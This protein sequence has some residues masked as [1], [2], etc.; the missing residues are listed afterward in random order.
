MILYNALIP[1]I[2]LNDQDNV[3]LPFIHYTHSYWIV[4]TFTSLEPGQT[5]ILTFGLSDMSPS[6]M[7][8]ER[9]LP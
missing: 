4:M 6:S 3:R 9:A 1:R 2:T 7:T 8:A 5:R